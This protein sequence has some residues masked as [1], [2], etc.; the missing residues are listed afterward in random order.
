ML[1]VNDAYAHPNFF[2]GID[3][4][5]GFKTRYTAVNLIVCIHVCLLNYDRLCEVL[6]QQFLTCNG[7]GLAWNKYGKISQ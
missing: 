2:S 1:N 3:E 7:C 6:P 5:T 4:M